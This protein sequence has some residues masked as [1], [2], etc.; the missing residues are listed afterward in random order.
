[1]FWA[2]ADVIQTKATMHVK[3]ETI[4]GFKSDMRPS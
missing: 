4:R 1:V 2:E 3:R